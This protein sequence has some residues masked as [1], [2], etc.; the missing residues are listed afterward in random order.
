M[1]KELEKKTPVAEKE[2]IFFPFWFSSTFLNSYYFGFKWIE[3]L[4]LMEL[5]V[6]SKHKSAYKNQKSAQKTKPKKKVF[7]YNP[8]SRCWYP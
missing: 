3:K 7:N 4:T 8:V 1:I 5:S 6:L 2:L